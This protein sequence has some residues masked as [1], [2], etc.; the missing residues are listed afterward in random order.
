MVN[1]MA[2]PSAV[3]EPELARH[4]L[5]YSYSI[6][7]TQYP[8]HIRGQEDRDGRQQAKQPLH[9]SQVGCYSN[10]AA[11]EHMCL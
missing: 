2:F 1:A 3:S 4:H 11:V 7:E 10:I 6:D 8:P 5:D 9:T